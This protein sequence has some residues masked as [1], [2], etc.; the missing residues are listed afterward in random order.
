MEKETL[1]CVKPHTYD[2]KWREAGKPYEVRRR[3]SGVL[4]ALGRASRSKPDLG[5]TGDAI[6]EPAKVAPAPAAAA[7]EV[8]A[9]AIDVDQKAALRAEYKELFGKA[10]PGRASIE[11]LAAEIEKAR[12]A[13]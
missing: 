5:S 4:I 6:D 3:H 9:D 12:A 8:P 7:V 13:E 10:A 2:M 11:T 1:Y